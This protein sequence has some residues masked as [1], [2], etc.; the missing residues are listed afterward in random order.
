MNVVSMLSAESIN[1]PL[2]SLGGLTIREW[3]PTSSFCT[4]TLG[5]PLGTAYPNGVPKTVRKALSYAYDYNGFVAAVYPDTSGGGIY[6]WS[7]FGMSSPFTDDSVDHPGPAPDLLAARAILIAD[8]IYAAALAARDLSLA[9]T[10]AE[11]EAVAASNPIDS[12][13]FL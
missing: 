13:S 8:P 5:L 3:F 10:T 12:F 4:D 11:W 1:K 6:C 9:N 2:A 7:P